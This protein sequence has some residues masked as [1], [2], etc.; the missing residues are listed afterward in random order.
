MVTVKYKDKIK[1]AR[2]T[3]LVQSFIYFQNETMP[4]QYPPVSNGIFKT[5]HYEQ[6][7]LNMSNTYS[8]LFLLRL[9]L[10]QQ[11]ASGSPPHSF[12]TTY[13][14]NLP[15]HRY[16]EKLFQGTVP[17]RRLDFSRHFSGRRHHCGSVSSNPSQLNV[18]PLGLFLCIH[19][20]I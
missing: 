4:Q 19:I 3:V 11:G 14:K 9:Q 12:P 5:Q 18:Y 13:P 17:A 2:L 15:T 16:A 7:N 10:F 20:F 8:F 1:K 6:M